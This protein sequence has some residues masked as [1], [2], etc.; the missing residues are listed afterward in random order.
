MIE[1]LFPHASLHDHD[2]ALASG[3]INCVHIRSPVR[4]KGSGSIRHR[5]QVATVAAA[6]LCR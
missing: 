1:P 6:P 3:L 5:Y 4:G 2:L